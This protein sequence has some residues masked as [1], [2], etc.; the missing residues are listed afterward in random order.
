MYTS[1]KQQIFLNLN[2]DLFRME[3]SKRNIMQA[4]NVNLMCNFKFLSSHI[5][6]KETGKINF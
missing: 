3:L 4:T 6:R 5:K 2:K 1:F